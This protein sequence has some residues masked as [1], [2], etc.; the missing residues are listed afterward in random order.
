[1]GS[2][3]GRSEQIV[4]HQHLGYVC[5]HV[6]S[7]EGLGQSS[8]THTPRRMTFTTA[9]MLCAIPGALLVGSTVLLLYKVHV[10]KQVN[11]ILL[12]K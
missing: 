2:E 1:M 6:P 11:M 8:P 10:R 12:Y 7:E 5:E 9:A 4:F 3:V